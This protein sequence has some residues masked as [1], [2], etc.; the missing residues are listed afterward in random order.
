MKPPNMV[1]INCD[2]LGYGDLGCYGS[3]M[4]A[5]PHLD[6]LAG[7]G[8]RLTDF[9]VGSPVCSASRAAL[10]TGCYPQRIGMPGVLFPG[11]DTGLHPAEETI[12]TR[13]KR[14]GY[15]TQIVGK[16]HC[17]D[18]PE[19]LPTRF[20]FDHYYGL[21]YSNDM[22]RQAR[23][24]DKRTEWP[25]LP[26]LR[27]EDVIQ[28]QPDQ[29]SLTERYLEESVR[30]I[31]AHRE[32]PFFLYLAHMYV[33]LPLYVPE[34]FLREAPH[35]YAAAVA[36]IDWAAG[37]IM[38][39]L[40][41][42]GL[43]ED[44]L[45]I[46]TSDNGSRCDYGKSNGPLRGYKGTTWEGGQRVPCILRWPGRIPAGRVC[47]ELTTAMDLLPT[48]DRLAGGDGTFAQPI[49]GKD[50][51]ALLF[52]KEGA[53]SPHEGFACYR[54]DTL[55]AVRKGDWKLHFLASPS[56]EKRWEVAPVKLLYNLAE[57]L[58]ERQNLYDRHPDHVAE[59]TAL[60][61]AYRRAFGD[62]AAGLDTG[63]DCRP[64]GRVENPLPLTV[65]DRHYPYYMAE[66]DLTDCG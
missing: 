46:F 19:F 25:P 53:A 35:P 34:R 24:G 11:Q 62:K 59:L 41:K 66:Y 28:Q 6:R 65:F 48:L 18:Q 43:E 20:G 56:D 27:D 38:R 10:M 17:G 33:H 12:A 60:A 31:R 26:L 49:D 58:G 7:Q 42:L 2:D 15:A 4:Q 30:F 47:H 16:W 37:V 45:L 29:A 50:I 3:P 57:D 39:E 13:L 5:T 54:N 23:P 32:Q 1:L 55:H 21:P 64:P 61:D 40:R 9:H 14:R 22:G 52:A 36:C 63:R 8:M 51:A 44:T